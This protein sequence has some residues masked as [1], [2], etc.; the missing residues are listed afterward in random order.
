MAMG[1]S[2]VGLISGHPL[3]RVQRARTAAV[4]D[5]VSLPRRFVRL[6]RRWKPSEG[7]DMS[8]TPTIQWPGRSGSRYQYWIYPLGT[9]FK[10]KP[11][12]YIFAKEVQPGRW[13]PIYVGQTENLGARL[14][15]HE[16]EG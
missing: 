11:G 5:A 4:R 3:L 15:A 13:R 10:E 6:C 1:T 16:K 7:A 9:S 2:S 14:P 8:S 12:N